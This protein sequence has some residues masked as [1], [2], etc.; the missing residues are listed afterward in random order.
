MVQMKRQKQQKQEWTAKIW[1]DVH[2]ASMTHDHP[3][4]N[5]SATEASAA[6]LAVAANVAGSAEASV[7]GSTNATNRTTKPQPADGKDD[8]EANHYIRLF[9]LVK[10]FWRK[11]FAENF[12]AH[13]FLSTRLF[14]TSLRQN[15]SQN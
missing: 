12:T 2:F 11:S 9:L 4:R 5:C 10:I 7:A 3:K 6:A 15:F 1:T 13:G 8:K 14:V